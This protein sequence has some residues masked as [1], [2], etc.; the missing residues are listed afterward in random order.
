MLDQCWSSVGVAF[1]GV[2]RY[3][4]GKSFSIRPQARE[5]VTHG[6]YSK[7]RNPIYVFGSM[8]ILGL[9]LVLQKPVLWVGLAA[10]VLSRLSA[11]GMKRVYRKKPSETPSG[12][13]VRR[14][15]FENV[16][17]SNARTPV[18]ALAPVNT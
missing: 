14:L 13:A 11:P 1:I 10:L 5:L 9:I 18:F 7:I 17:L 15:G 12:S 8:I 4:L 16:I 6:L 3:Q 2:P